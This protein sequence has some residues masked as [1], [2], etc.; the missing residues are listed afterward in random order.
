LFTV[1]FGEAAMKQNMQNPFALYPPRAVAVGETWSRKV[2]VSKGLPLVIEGSYALKAR[3]AGVAEIAMDAKISPNPEAGPV[4]LGTGKMT[5]NLSGDQHG[6]ARIDEATGWTKSLTTEQD[7]SGTIAVDMPGDKD[8]AIP[9]T[10][11][12]KV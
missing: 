5:Y 4:E 6:S 2:V 10:V 11:K 7:V 1:Q 12:S 8:A 3:T 9:I